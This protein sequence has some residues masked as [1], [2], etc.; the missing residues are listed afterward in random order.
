MYVK[1]KVDEENIRAETDR[2]AILKV[3]TRQRCNA[4]LFVK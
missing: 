2:K 1:K 3:F 4:A